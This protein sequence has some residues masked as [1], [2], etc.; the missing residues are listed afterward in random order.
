M[1]SKISYIKL[2]RADLRHR[3]WLAAL[4]SIGLFLEMPVF[5]MLYI[6]SLQMQNREYIVIEE[7]R[8]AFPGLLNGQSVNHLAAVI[9]VIAV[10]CALTGFGYIHS[11]D[12]TDFFH[13]LP[14]KRGQWF[15][16]NYLSGLIIFL[17]PYVICSALTIAVGGANGIM[18]AQTAANSAEAAAGGIL[19][20]LL[21]YHTCILAAMLTGQTVTGILAALVLAVYPFMVFSLFNALKGIFFKTYYGIAAV[22]ADT[23]AE[24]LSPAGLYVSLIDHTADG[25]AGSG[26]FIASLVMAALL[27]G[28][29]LLLYRI[30]PSETAGNALAF[31]RTA[32]VFKV[33]ICIP[34]A[35]FSSI[36]AK[37]FM[38]VTGTKW[39]IVL[40]LLA[41][42]ILCGVIEFIYQQDLRMLL[43]GWV[44]SVISVAG[45]ALVL[46]IFQFDLF[47]YDTY[48]PDQNRVESISFRP[49]SFWGYFEYPEDYAGYEDGCLVGD[50]ASA[51]GTEALY[52]LAQTGVGNL[53][54]GYTPEV[55]DLA[56]TDS[57]ISGDYINTVFRYKL[58]G[59][60]EVYRRYC[61]G[62]EEILSALEELC[63]SEDV[64]KEMFPIYHVDTSK[65]T[66]VSF[67]DAYGVGTL[68]ELSDD[69]IQALLDAYK[70]DVMGVDINVLAANNPLGELMLGIPD[71]NTALSVESAA[72]NADMEYGDSIQPETLTLGSFYVYEGYDNTLACMEEYG[73]TF[74][75]EIAPEDVTQITL[76]LY[77]ES[78]RSGKYTELLSELTPGAERFAYDDGSQ[79]I[80]VRAE[81]DIRTVL[82]HIEPYNSGI[83]GG[84]TGLGDYADIQFEEGSSYYSYKI[85]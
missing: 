69:Q 23:L 21:I 22:L 50:G 18:T 80:T 41:A 85:E 24:V 15:V 43:K 33:M 77:S 53:E 61:L 38:G 12:K 36:I 49:E 10:L 39:I 9:A 74:R 73:Y 75:T 83:L 54:E 25:I 16:V 35:L 59:G 76:Y 46:C 78:M 45:V 6:D 17:L 51:E 70:K 8:A 1:T 66:S 14:V 60:R 63:Q 55:L 2:I 64:R 71:E 29:A 44:S 13:S 79:E 3:G 30:Y 7:L 65:V 57:E 81:E 84:G 5:I 19:A 20:F 37:L 26:L 56:S 40:S 67:R 68:A 58:S 28:G 62:R 47:G 32:P 48:V 4:V 31:P 27:L 82:E 11:K 52:R 42:V 34:A 72:V